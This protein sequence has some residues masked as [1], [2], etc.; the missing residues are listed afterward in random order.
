[1]KGEIKDKLTDL[2][3]I[4]AI[5]LGIV[6]FTGMFFVPE[7]IMSIIFSSAV[8]CLHLWMICKII[9]R[10]KN[11]TRAQRKGVLNYFLYLLVS[12]IIIFIAYK[13]WVKNEDLNGLLGSFGY[14]GLGYCWVI[15]HLACKKD[16][17]E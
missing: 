8:A 12:V 15:G 11:M 9:A 4:L 7:K 3:K 13:G 1:M 16:E 14:C 6:G 2:Y 10:Y 17:E 5:I